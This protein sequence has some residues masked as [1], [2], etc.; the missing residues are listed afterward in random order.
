MSF[1]RTK[2]SIAQTAFQSK[3]AAQVVDSTLDESAVSLL[4]QTFRL[5]P[6]VVSIYDVD[7]KQVVYSNRPLAALLG[8]GDNFRPKE[9]L[10]HPNDESNVEAQFQRLLEADD[11]ESVSVRFRLKQ[12]DGTWKWFSERQVIFK[13]HDDGRVAQ[14]LKTTR[15]IQQELPP[16]GDLLYRITEYNLPNFAMLIFDHQLRYSVATG[17]L[18]RR[19][20]FSKGEVEGR[21][22]REVVSP[23]IADW[24]EPAYQAALMGAEIHLER[25]IDGVFVSV[26]C[27][28]V[29][30]ESGEITAG[31]VLAEDITDEKQAMAALIESEQRFAQFSENMQSLFWMLDTANKTPLYFSPAFESIWGVKPEQALENLRIIGTRVYPDDLPLVNQAYEESLTIGKHEIKFRINHPDGTVHWLS[32]RAFPIYDDQGVLYRVAGIMDDITQ[33]M[34]MEKVT[35]DLA[36]EQE[37]MRLLSRFIGTTS[38][39]LRTPLTIINTS[40]YLLRK[41]NDPTK[42]DERLGIIEHQV[43]Q[44]TRLIGQMHMLLRIES[45]SDNANASP[46][47]LNKM[48]GRLENDYQPNITKKELK[49]ELVFGDEL[50]NLNIN[51]DLLLVALQNVLENAINYTNAGTIRLTTSYQDNEIMCTVEDNGVGIDAEDLPHIFERFYKVDKNKR[52]TGVAAGLGLAITQRIM[53]LGGGRIEVE[54]Q[55]GKGS[56]F[57]L[58]WPVAA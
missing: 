46:V 53:E 38:H 31:M 39:E 15:D 47:A 20:G 41:T 6:D 44:L 42:Q 1:S 49:L 13:R 5:L 35:F 32:S 28:P 14:I 22:L 56:T 4:E 54:S 52:R 8:Y 2:S 57:R 30:S 50:P 45:I 34:Q 27:L 24:L 10:L 48:L 43:A 18:L 36:L 11:D 17:I 19:M 3:A 16:S 37:R 21:T 29:R 9:W 40:L 7:S 12:A 51:P 58:I 23:E 25:L 55:V 33:N 26:H